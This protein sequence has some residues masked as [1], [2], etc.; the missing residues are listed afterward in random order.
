LPHLQG[1]H[2]LGTHLSKSSSAAVQQTNHL[3][4]KVMN[5]TCIILHL[6]E[7]HC[8]EICVGRHIGCMDTSNQSQSK[9]VGR[10]LVS[11][12]DEECKGLMYIIHDSLKC[13]SDCQSK[14][15]CSTCQG[16]ACSGD[17]PCNY[18]RSPLYCQSVLPISSV[19]RVCATGY[20]VGLHR[21]TS[22]SAHCQ[23]GS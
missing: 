9:C 23:W 7:N 15:Q 12:R 3:S 14:G 1:P 16:S 21:C 4:Q 5:T 19:L 6:N 11:V 2:N 22:R 18:V 8:V 20:S 17:C 10:D 13:F